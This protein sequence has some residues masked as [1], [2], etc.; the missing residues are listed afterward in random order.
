MCGMGGLVQLAK[1]AIVSPAELQAIT[2]TKTSNYQRANGHNA[3]IIHFDIG[4][5]G[6]A[7]TLKIQGATAN[8]GNFADM[9]DSNSNLMSTG[10]ISA[11]RCQL[12]VGIPEHFKIVATED[13]NGSTV[14]VSYELLTV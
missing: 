13:V 4:A 2:A 9:Y 6:G 10:S 14:S 3:V 5:G 11:D 12:F 8:N 7:W 1:G